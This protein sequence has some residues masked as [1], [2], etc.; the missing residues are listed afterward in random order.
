MATLSLYGP[1]LS[2]TWNP[3]IL[4]ARSGYARPF[5]SPMP[6]G[7][8]PARTV[9]IFGEF[10]NNF[11]FISS[12]D[13]TAL[14]L[15]G[16]SM[17]GATMALR[18]GIPTQLTISYSRIQG[19]H[20][21]LGF[22]QRYYDPAPSPRYGYSIGNL[23][24]HQSYF[25]MAIVGMGWT[26][27][28][29]NVWLIT[30]GVMS[31][32]TCSNARLR[33]AYL[34]HG[35]ILGIRF[36]PPSDSGDRKAF[37]RICEKDLPPPDGCSVGQFTVHTMKGDQPNTESISGGPLTPGW[38]VEINAGDDTF[39]QEGDFFELSMPLILEDPA[40]MHEYGLTNENGFWRTSQQR[41]EIETRVLG[42]WVPTVDDELGSVFMAHVSGNDQN[43]VT[44]PSNEIEALRN[45]ESM[46]YGSSP[47]DVFNGDPST[48]RLIMEYCG[49]PGLQNF[50]AG[51]L[52]GEFAEINGLHYEIVGHPRND[53]ISVSTFAEE[54]GS[55]LDTVPASL[56]IFQQNFWMSAEM[57][58]G[59]AG[60]RAFSSFSNG[61]SGSSN[62]F[63]WKAYKPGHEAF[64]LKE[65]EQTE[66]GCKNLLERHIKDH[67]PGS[68]VKAYTKFERWKASIGDELYSIKS[69]QITEDEVSV[70]I[71]G[72]SQSASGIGFVTPDTPYSPVSPFTLTSA[73]ADFKPGLDDL[74][75]WRIIM[76][77]IFNGGIYQ[78]PQNIPDDSIFSIVSNSFT[79]YPA[80]I[81]GKKSYGL[82]NPFLYISTQ[83]GTAQGVAAIECPLSGQ[84]FVFFSD[85]DNNYLAY[86]TSIDPEWTEEREQG[87]VRVGYYKDDKT[88]DSDYITG[89]NFNQGSSGSGAGD[90][91]WVAMPQGTYSSE[92]PYFATKITGAG[93]IDT[94]Y[95]RKNNLLEESVANEAWFP[96]EV[97]PFNGNKTFF[98]A[99]MPVKESS[100]AGL[101]KATKSNL[102]SLLS[103]NSVSPSSGA[104]PVFQVTPIT[105]LVYA[106]STKD[107]FALSDGT[108]GLIYSTELFKW[109]FTSGGEEE[110][111]NNALCVITSD[112]NA[113]DWGSPKVDKPKEG[114][115]DSE[116]WESPLV[117]LLD[118]ELSGSLVRSD[119]FELYA[120]GYVYE[121]GED[122]YRDP[123]K[124]SL[125]LYRVA[126]PDFI[127]GDTSDIFNSDGVKIGKYRKSKFTDKFGR[128]E[129]S[130]AGAPNLNESF[131]KIIG[132]SETDA[133]IIGSITNEIV[134]PMW[135][136][137][138]IRLFVYSE[139][140]GG[141]ISLVSENLG[142]EWGVEAADTGDPIIY[143]RGE[144]GYPVVAKPGVFGQIDSHNLLF[145]IANN[146]LLCKRIDLTGE[147]GSIQEKLDNSIPTV[148]A[149]DIQEHKCVST[150]DRGGRLLVYYLTA[151]GILSAAVSDDCGDH[152][153]TLKNF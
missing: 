115:A 17:A 43:L 11:M 28:L 83:K 39:I 13:L 67:G 56:K 38:E 119:I 105:K 151:Q 134:A 96:F 73:Y 131:V 14:T 149:V 25:S 41:F 54:D 127:E 68:S 76:D 126:I 128:F 4:A 85:P 47:N 57:F 100:G 55:R 52:I 3:W 74:G 59:G 23:F 8:F 129:G 113:Y 137:R 75:Q 63:S 99:Y 132:N 130:G 12:S 103:G 44:L 1:Q 49:G 7:W 110:L 10:S 24:K 117:V 82:G 36:G 78:F 109:S 148:V 48:V 89:M 42:T 135:M 60:I 153:E 53:T 140:Y 121:P 62:S 94:P 145:Y 40:T 104:A 71:D 92:C 70:E 20:G 86:R 5:S 95:V 107:A 101:V 64:L 46:D 80:S 141:I 29:Q 77:G 51:N 142:D 2:S 150:S 19:G 16:W 81:P 122:A 66:L 26:I 93:G 79:V 31:T 108:I 65:D 58:F 84:P 90:A 102:Q 136:G 9:S 61:F 106:P 146:S 91:Y 133:Q 22:T 138:D 69:L 114:E 125:A 98:P 6:E 15:L 27:A 116:E 118:F 143:T 45:Q 35:K 112:N 120:F 87:L 72:E 111:S 30:P 152:W 32:E 33:R 34:K 21:T 18:I 147:G 88:S 37:I 97:Y 50:C 144:G 124:L 139:F 123:N